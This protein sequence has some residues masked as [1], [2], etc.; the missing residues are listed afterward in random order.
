MLILRRIFGSSEIFG[1]K[2]WAARNRLLRRTELI[3][4]KNK[5]SKKARDYY[6]V[7][8]GSDQIWAPRGL[9]TA[10]MLDFVPDDVKKYPMPQV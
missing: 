1:F 9:D 5:L 3:L 4:D 10:Y 6:A 7:V 2:F 8:C